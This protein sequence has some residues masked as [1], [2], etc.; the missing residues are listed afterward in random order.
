MS[1]LRSLRNSASVSARRR[2]TLRRRRPLAEILEARTLLSLTIQV[3][4]NADAIDPTFSA[5]SLREAI[6]I[7]NGTLTYNPLTDVNVPKLV[8]GTISVPTSG[9]PPVPNTI[10]FNLAS[11]QTTINV[12]GTPLPAITS[13][14]IVN[15][16]SQS[17]SAVSA[18]DKTEVVLNTAVVRI[19]GVSLGAPASG[20]G[21]DGL[22]ITAPDCVVDGLIITGFS[23]AGMSI[24]NPASGAPAQGNWLWGNFLGAVPDSTS[25]RLFANDPVSLLNGSNPQPSP[26]LRPGNLAEGI[27]I[28]ASN[29]RVGGDTPGLPNVIANN[30]FDVNGNSVGGVGILIDTQSG[31]GNLIQGN[32]ILHNA[33]EGV[34]VKSSNNT[35]GEALLGGGNVIGGNLA[36]G[37]LITGTA[38]PTVQGNNLWGNLI[39]TELGTS[40]GKILKGTISDPNGAEGLR[41][42]DSPKNSI[43]GTSIAARNVIGANNLDGVAIV[44]ANSTSNRLLNNYIGFNIV[45]GLIVFLPNQNGVLVT[46]PGNFIGDAISN[47]GNTI[48][49]NRLHGILIQGSAASGNTVA[50]N[51]IGLNPNGA[52][53]FGNAFDGI[54]IDNAPNNVIG[55][56]TIAARNT[57]SSNNNGIVIVGLVDGNPAHDT[58]TGNR[59]YGNFIG[60]TVDGLIDLGN[61]VDGVILQNA[62]LN[63]IGDTVSGAGNV[64][65]GN[66]RGVRIT[67]ALS[68]NNNIRGN[69]IGTDLTGTAVIHNEIDGVLI[70]SGASNNTVGGIVAAAGNIIQHN[71]G[72]GVNLD[73]GTGNAVLSNSIYAN[74]VTGI[75]QNPVTHADNLQVAPVLTSVTPSGTSTNVQGTFAGL[76]NA[77]YTLQFFSS[78]TQDSPGVA[79]GQTLLGSYVVTTD[80]TG[81]YV[82]NQGLNVQV[83]TG[84]FVTATA[85]DSG[86]NSSNFSNALPAVP[87]SF[88]LSSATYSVNETDGSITIIV[89]RIVGVPGQLGGDVAV[90]YTVSGGTAVAGTDYTTVS[91]TLF[92]KSTDPNTKSFTIPI[93]NPHTVGGS[94]TTNITL[95]T[96]PV[97][98]NGATLGAP[99]SAVLT[100]VDNSLTSVQLSSATAS[101]NE[102]AG[103]IAFTISRNSN[104]GTT[105]ID[106]ATAAGTASAGVNYTAT[107]GIVTFIAGQTTAIVP[108]TLLDDNHLDGPLTFTLAL[109]NPTN[110]VVGAIGST[111][112]TIVDTDNAGTLQVAKPG[113]LAAPGSSTVSVQVARVGGAAGTVGVQYLAMA[114]SA[115][116]GIDFTP[117]GGILQF[118]PGETLKTLVIPLLHTSTP[119]PNLTFNLTLSAP[120]GGATLGRLVSSL[121]TIQHGGSGGGGT[122]NPPPPSTETV[123]PTV[124]DL[125]PV[126]NPLGVFAVIVSFS[127]AM[128]PAR[129]VDVSNYGTF[130]RTPG[131]DGVFGT[132]DDGA[133]QI[134]S[135]GYN[136]TTHQAVL[137][138]A[139]PLPLGTFASITL[140][141]NA[142]LAPPKGL[143]DLAGNF[144]D[145]TGTGSFPGSAFTTIIAEGNVL[146]YKDRSG[147]TVTLKLGGQGLMTLRRGTDGEAQELRFVGTL[148][149]KSNL[150]GTVQR[151]RRGVGGVTTIPSIGGANGVNIKLRPPAFRIGGISAAAVDVLATSGK[152][153]GKR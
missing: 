112:T 50:G 120:T 64:I 16:Y 98:A 122:T 1:K 61:A 85:T 47:A 129:A 92:F 34:L 77:K 102:N 4:T 146:S 15:G 66:N 151:P 2:E 14:L 123:P 115:L 49:N 105:T 7:S 35:I 54:Y 24:S 99:S 52:S 149:G 139:S 53:A 8:S 136:A 88:T 42:Q 26:A 150:S 142:R 119:G 97:T 39:G 62:P 108:V 144:L 40:D 111:V 5:I 82:L 48:D 84:Q 143:T 3:N 103:S 73:D 38:D 80:A 60:T 81:A 65:S 6:E 46:S 37:V 74:S 32:A 72:S 147:D 23:G 93:L 28:T 29:N 125:Q 70:T 90:D 30:G 20:P 13:P 86:N 63:D 140:N 31:T 101:V 11:G 41:I 110:G 33:T 27:R 78:P 56:T 21:Y 133:I 44:G 138:L 67:G 89:N 121:V 134:S 87:I 83:P 104:L 12:T 100:I 152:L 75:F 131:N 76:S 57:I 10:L 68:H 17:G 51:V 126:A 141:S 45:G 19:D 43:G 124:L 117:F 137:F 106:Y 118:N 79:Q 95:S 114:G 132:F 36:Q 148:P 145:G 58:A 96:D 69:F 94:V 25:G 9:A 116:P 91:G 18:P 130:L 113:V 59:V 127:E 109:S 107:S 135:A 153:H 71:V 55:G 128:D 22:D